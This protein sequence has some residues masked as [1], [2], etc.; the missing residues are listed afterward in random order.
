M[1][2]ANRRQWRWVAVGVAMLMLVGCGG[3]DESPNQPTSDGDSGS[4]SSGG[5]SGGRP[6]EDQLKDV[7]LDK[8]K[9]A[10]PRGAVTGELLEAQPRPDVA[11]VQQKFA[12]AQRRNP[13]WFRRYVQ[14][15]GRTDRPL[16][17][18]EN[19]GITREEYTLLL[20]G[21]SQ[22]VWRNPIDGPLEFNWS[23][24]RVVLDGG[25]ILPELTGVAI[26]F[27][28]GQAAIRGERLD[29]LPRYAADQTVPNLGKFDLWRWQAVL[30]EDEENAVG[31]EA[32][33]QAVIT[34]ALSAEG[35]PTAFVSCAIMP[36]R[37]DAI[38]RDQAIFVQFPPK[39]AFSLPRD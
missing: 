25:N 34:L 17:W 6:M 23:G 28:T 20:Q 12:A 10:L 29:A 33:E 3:G 1:N 7:H 15:H 19:F 38:G 14:E 31:A 26:D 9:E 30:D 13:Q 36:V 27:R 4:A 39:T 8:L 35:P 24:D 16:P 18:H 5:D 22:R 32:R 37:R 21:Q 11:R 2:S